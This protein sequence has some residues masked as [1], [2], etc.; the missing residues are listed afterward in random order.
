VNIHADFVTRIPIPNANNTD[1]F[2]QA[3]IDKRSFG[4]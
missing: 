1:D 2:E 3:A 4:N